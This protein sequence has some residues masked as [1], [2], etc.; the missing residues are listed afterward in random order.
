MPR[1]IRPRAS[2][3]C[4]RFERC[5]GPAPVAL[6]IMDKH[7]DPSSIETKWYK[8]WE[9]RGVFRAGTHAADP[10]C[11]MI[12]PPNVTGSLHMGHAFQDT[13]MDGLTRLHRMRGHA[14]LWQPGTDHAG[15]ATQMVVDRRLSAQG[16]S[17]HD[18]G[19]EAFIDEIWKWK[20]ES[21]GH[22]T[23]QLRRMGAAVD[24]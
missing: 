14:T 23:R 20:A 19:R 3:A 2:S 5:I 16:Q 8:D 17:R 15:I 12:P 6:H 7:Y 1:R 9:E 24:W 18:L 11:I 21:G 4:E 10:Y 13:I 22:I